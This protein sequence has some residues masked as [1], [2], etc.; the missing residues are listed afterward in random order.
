MI[1]VSHPFVKA[2]FGPLMAATC[3]ACVQA[4]VFAPHAHADWRQEMGTFRVGIATKEGEPFKTQALEGFRLAMSRALSMPV[5]IFQA[6]N[7]SS[8]IDAAASSRIQYAILSSLGFVTLDLTCDCMSPIVAPTS[9]DGATMTR[10]VLFVNVDEVAS[11]EQ[12]AGKRLAIGPDSSLTGSILPFAQFKLGEASLREA[13]IELIDVSSVEQAVEALADGTVDGFFGWDLVIPDSSQVFET[14]LSM[15][16]KNYPNINAKSIW[17]SEP[18]RF[19]PHVIHESVPEEAETA[20]RAMLEDLDESA[21]IAYRTISPDLSGGFVPVSTQD[22]IS[23][24]ALIRSIA[25][26]TTLTEN[27]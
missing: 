19:G 18:V 1:K 11:L 13:G 23:A 25:R 6:R 17:A 9:A 27:E 3:L 8:L 24:Y 22:Y 15:K 12:L 14:S 20:L 7:A 5:E 21:P 4:T 10:S 2:N 26:D 16:L